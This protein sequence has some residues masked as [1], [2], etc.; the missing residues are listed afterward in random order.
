MSYW[1]EDDKSNICQGS[2]QRI[3]GRKIPIDSIEIFTVT[4]SDA[5]LLAAAGYEFKAGTKLYP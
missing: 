5:V 4:E 3:T 2:L 1:T